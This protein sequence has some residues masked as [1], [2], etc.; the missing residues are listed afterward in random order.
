MEIFISWSGTRGRDAAEGLKGLMESIFGTR[1]SVW[2]S[3][4]S[5][6]KGRR[7]ADHLARALNRC[8][9]GIVCVTRES[10]NSS[11]LLFEAGAISAAMDAK[12]LCPV[13]ID[14]PPTELDGPLAQFQSTRLNRRDIEALMRTVNH[15]IERPRTASQF[16]TAYS[17][18]WATLARQETD[19]FFRQLNSLDDYAQSLVKP[20]SSRQRVKIGG[21]TR[22]I[23]IQ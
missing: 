19:R 12:H 15:G 22:R 21:K 18:A 4:A 6:P 10:Q 20:L 3:E 23:P 7:W 17:K 9:F 5:I 8:E 13:L 2:F 1:I 11:W 16:A 14:V